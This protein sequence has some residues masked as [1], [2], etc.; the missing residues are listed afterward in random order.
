MNENIRNSRI[1]FNFS[2]EMIRGSVVYRVDRM[3]MDHYY[4]THRERVIC[5]ATD[6]ENSRRIVEEYMSYP[7]EGQR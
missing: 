2:N 5:I 1:F 3:G 6:D 4:Y 7:G